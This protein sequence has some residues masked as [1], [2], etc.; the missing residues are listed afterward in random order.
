MRQLQVQKGMMMPIDGGGAPVVFQYNPCELNGPSAEAEY[1]TIGVGGSEHPYM[2][3]SH[4]KE[5]VIQFELVSARDMGEGQVKAMHQALVALTKPEKKGV[6]PGSPPRVMFILGGF[7]RE[8][9]IV[10][11]V[12]PRFRRF[13]NPESLMPNEGRFQ[14]TLWKWKE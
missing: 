9:C 5:S 10:K 11:S 6:G 2:Q 8:K 1:A 3:Y 14:I 12:Q 13:H 7:I 4:G